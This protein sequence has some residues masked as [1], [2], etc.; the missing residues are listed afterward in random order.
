M[1]EYPAP[2]AD[3]CVSTRVSLL[4]NFASVPF[5]GAMSDADAYDNV[6][7]VEEG[8]I[9]TGHRNDF[10]Y[11]S[12]SGVDAAQRAWMAES[13]QI[14]PELAKRVSR[15][16]AFLAKGR[17]IGLYVNELDHLRIEGV[18]PGF[19]LQRAADLGMAAD[20]WIGHGA[21]YA[22]DAQFG[23]LTV[24]P[25]MCGAGMTA[26][27]T[28]HLPMIA[29]TQ[30]RD[31]LTE[32]LRSRGQVLK[33]LRTDLGEPG[34]S[35]FQLIHN[36]TLSSTPED[37][38]LSLSESVEELVTTERDIRG[39]WKNSDL[40]LLEDRVFRDLAIV[41]AARLMNEKEMC[42]RV[43]QL[44]FAAASG[45]V[46]MPFEALDQLRMNLSDAALNLRSDAVL[47]DRQRDEMRA[48]AMRREL[49]FILPER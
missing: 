29:A 23:Y 40:L 32:Q 35:M 20:S 6:A 16:A 10:N 48:N 21:R 19:Q 30:K 38:L 15:G 1:N 14:S 25:L 43:S 18:M 4:R 3:V 12:M 2:W 9:R 17:T 8:L 27:V 37:A 34:D 13:G 11:I 46:E 28:M 42:L 24:N 47:S 7:R 36:V 33:P 26:S 22:Y 31:A 44:R 49:A 39:K 45:L 5:D 41:E